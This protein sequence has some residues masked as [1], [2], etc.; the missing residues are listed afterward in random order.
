MIRI[1]DIR[2][3]LSQEYVLNV[4]FDRADTNFDIKKRF[5]SPINGLS[6]DKPACHYVTTASY[7]RR[8]VHETP[9]ETQ[10][11]ERNRRC[12]LGNDAIEN[13]KW[14]KNVL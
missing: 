7:Q 3:P 13:W 11:L 4:E 2:L 10:L 6:C 14:G 12:H 1:I 9:H 5:Q 8:F